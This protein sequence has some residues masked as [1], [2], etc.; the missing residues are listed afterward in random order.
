MRMNTRGGTIWLR[1]SQC[2]LLPKS[3]PGLWLGSQ[4]MRKVIVKLAF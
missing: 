3:F 4:D 2:R 1:E